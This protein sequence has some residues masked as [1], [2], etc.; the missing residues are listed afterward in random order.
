MSYCSSRT[1]LPEAYRSYSL[2]PTTTRVSS[3]LLPPSTLVLAAARVYQVSKRLG[4]QVPL[5]SLRSRLSG[6][7][8][9]QLSM[10]FYSADSQLLAHSSTAPA[11]LHSAIIVHVIPPISPTTA[12]Q[13]VSSTDKQM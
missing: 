12:Q 4:W 2:V 3:L 9:T 10:N 5:L 13:E 1:A 6:E 8:Y 7:Y 11:L